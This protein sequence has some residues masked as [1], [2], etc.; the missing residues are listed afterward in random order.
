MYEFI[1][2]LGLKG[3]KLSYLLVTNDY[4]LIRF[5]K[6]AYFQLNQLVTNNE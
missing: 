2:N 6:K 3:Q 4:E 1:K 5:E